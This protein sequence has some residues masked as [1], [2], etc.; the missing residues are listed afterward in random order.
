MPDALWAKSDPAVVAGSLKNGCFKNSLIS[1]CSFKYSAV[2]TSP[3]RFIKSTPSTTVLLDPP[4]VLD[5][6]L[7]NFLRSIPKILFSAGMLVAS[8]VN[9]GHS[10]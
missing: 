4:E 9:D 5:F 1:A 8:M 7:D 3:Y 2:A 6:K 10:T